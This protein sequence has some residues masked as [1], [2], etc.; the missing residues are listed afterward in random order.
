M[1][2]ASMGLPQQS[3]NPRL[4]FADNYEQVLGNESMSRQL[5]DD[6]HVCQALLI[7]AYFVLAFDNV[8]NRLCAGLSKPPALP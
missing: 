5:I 7:G 4:S 8:N 3:A 6:F 2:L 1:I